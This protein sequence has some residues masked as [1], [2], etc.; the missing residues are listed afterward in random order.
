MIFPMRQTIA[1]MSCSPARRLQASTSSRISACAGTS[2]CGEDGG[3]AVGAHA[4]GKHSRAAKRGGE[5]HLGLSLVNQFYKLNMMICRRRE[6]RKSRL[7]YSLGLHGLP[8]EAKQAERAG[9]R[10]KGNGQSVPIDVK[11]TS[12]N[13]RPGNHRA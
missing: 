7:H 12:T 1:L 2:R 4:Y 3:P 11:I 10:C 6:Y 13:W 8:G 5:L 9:N